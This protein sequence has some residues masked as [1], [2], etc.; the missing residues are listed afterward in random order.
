[1]NSALG[2][3]DRNG[4]RYIR[5]AARTGES[6]VN[7]LVIFITLPVKHWPWLAFHVLLTNKMVLSASTFIFGR[8][9]RRDYGMSLLGVPKKWRAKPSGRSC[10]APSVLIDR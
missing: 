1:M 4:L 9:L 3:I 8:I 7:R 6:G 5:A 10:N 2:C